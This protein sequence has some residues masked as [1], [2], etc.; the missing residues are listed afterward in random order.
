MVEFA[1]PKL[2]RLASLESTVSSLPGMWSRFCTRHSRRAFVE[3]LV[4]LPQ[5]HRQNEQRR[6]L[7]GERL[8]GGHSDFGT[9]MRIDGAR[10]LTRHHRPH[11]VADWRS[12]SSILYSWPRAAP[13][14]C[15]QFSPD[16]EITAVSVPEVTMGS[17]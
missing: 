16:C 1:G 7:S 5:I 9:A 15:P 2:R 10:C 17:R 3:I 4:R 8:G 12:G 11:G 13:P 14:G 6:Q